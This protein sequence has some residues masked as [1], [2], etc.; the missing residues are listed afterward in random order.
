MNSD[1]VIVQDVERTWNHTRFDVHKV[2]Y[3]EWDNV[4]RGWAEEEDII[5]WEDCMEQGS[6]MYE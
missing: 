6:R 2:M 5:V 1:S 4:F 3:E